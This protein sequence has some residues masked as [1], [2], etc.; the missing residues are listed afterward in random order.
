M[1]PMCQQG[2]SETLGEIRFPVNKDPGRCLS[3]EDDSAGIR[4]KARLTFCCI[5]QS[6]EAAPYDVPRATL[7]SRLDIQGRNIPTKNGKSRGL[8]GRCF[9]IQALS[10]RKRLKVK[11]QRLP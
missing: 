9:S 11:L 2:N 1:H 8:E 7:K 5:D 10:Q 4:V 3:V 6:T